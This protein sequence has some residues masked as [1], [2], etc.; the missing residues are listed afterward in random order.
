MK[1][2][3]GVGQ[4]NKMDYNKHR[5]LYKCQIK[6]KIIINIECLECEYRMCQGCAVRCA[7]LEWISLF[8]K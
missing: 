3:I 4:K 6:K 2:N 8:L 5:V 7:S 1:K